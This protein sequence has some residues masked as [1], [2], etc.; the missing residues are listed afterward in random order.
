MTP[1]RDT[2]KYHLHNT[3]T[4]YGRTNCHPS[5]RTCPPYRRRIHPAIGQQGTSSTQPR[6]FAQDGNRVRSQYRTRNFRTSTV[7][8]GL[9]VHNNPQRGRTNWNPGTRHRTPP[10]PLGTRKYL[11][12]TSQCRK[13]C[14]RSRE[15]GS[16]LPPPVPPLQQ[17][18]LGCHGTCRSCRTKRT[19]AT[20]LHTNCNLSTCCSQYPV[21]FGPQASTSLHSQAPWKMRWMTEER[22]LSQKSDS[23]TSR[24][25]TPSRSQDTSC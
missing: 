23:G 6:G 15:S 25:R 2:E 24:L 21:P 1:C 13:P 4:N 11:P 9:L 3:A 7:T 10:C 17:P 18:G 8:P 5:P 12:H 14:R 19:W 16:Q 22:N 20:V